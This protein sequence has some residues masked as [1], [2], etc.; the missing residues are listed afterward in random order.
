MFSSVRLSHFLPGDETSRCFNWVRD[1][2]RPNVW[3]V[4]VEA[5]TSWQ[6]AV[7]R[8]SRCF[9][10]FASVDQTYGFLFKEQYES[11]IHHHTWHKAW[12]HRVSLKMQ[13][14]TLKLLPDLFF[15]T[16]PPFRHHIESTVTFAWI[17][18]SS[19]KI[20][21]WGFGPVFRGFKLGFNQHAERFAAPSWHLGKWN[22]NSLTLRTAAEDRLK[23]LCST[24]ISSE[25]GA[26]PHLGK[27]TILNSHLHRLKKI[28]EQNGVPPRD[29]VELRA[30][31]LLKT[32]HCCCFNAFYAPWI[33]F[34]ISLQS[35]DQHIISAFYVTDVT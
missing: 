11:H 28:W 12:F 15:S 26:N 18:Y 32:K 25:G 20:A 21:Q 22:S 30:V 7:R 27:K 8:A 23:F 4:H 1:G 33:S 9:Y 29:R 10:F 35:Q 34:F 31:K 19:I 17:M 3:T 24:T 6:S 14:W 13:A 2:F 5:P 16:S